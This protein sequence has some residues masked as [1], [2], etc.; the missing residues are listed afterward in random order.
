M[1]S[2]RRKRRSRVLRQRAPYI[3][4]IDIY[5]GAPWTEMDV[6]DLIAGLK[7]GD[8]IDDAAHH[9]CRSGTIDEV[10]R[11]AEELGLSYKSAGD[12]R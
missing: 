12:P 7:S 11:K 3:Q 1:S 10:R 2:L 4:S 9:L 8:T 5:D 6:E